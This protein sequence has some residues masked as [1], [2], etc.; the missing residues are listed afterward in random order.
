MTEDLCTYL[1]A[2][3]IAKFDILPH[4]CPLWLTFLSVSVLNG[5]YMIYELRNEMLKLIGLNKYI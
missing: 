1:N 3:F 5:L 4:H 2:H